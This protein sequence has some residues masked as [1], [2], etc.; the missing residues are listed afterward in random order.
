M[1]RLIT[2]VAA[3]K[4]ELL[5]LMEMQKFSVKKKTVGDATLYSGYNTDFLRVGMGNRNAYYNLHH[6][7]KER[8][9]DKILNI[10]LAGALKVGIDLGTVYK[11]NRIHALKDD[12]IIYPLNI[13]TLPQFAET[14]L[15]T[16]IDP[17]QSTTVKDDLYQSFGCILVDMEAHI[18]GRIAEQHQIPF[19][20]L[21]AVSD[22]ADENTPVQFK[23]NHIPIC[24]K[25]AKVVSDN[26]L[27][28]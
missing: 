4:Q 22:T 26:L 28:Q 19:Y 20:C 17:V 2:V 12:K 9:P 5:P 13:Q 3:F 10:G 24:D 11:I 6:Y 21:K 25:L 1:D 27:T 7:L 23:Q 15:V 14:C 18:I 8:M 16:S